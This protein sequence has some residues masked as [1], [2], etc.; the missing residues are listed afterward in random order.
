MI[1][2][3]LQYNCV[4]KYGASLPHTDPSS[5]LHLFCSFRFKICL[6]GGEHHKR[7]RTHDPVNPMNVNGL[8]EPFRTCGGGGSRPQ[9][10][11]STTAESCGTAAVSRNRNS[12]AGTP[13]FQSLA[14]GGSAYIRNNQ[15]LYSTSYYTE[16]SILPKKYL[17]LS[18]CSKGHFSDIFASSFHLPARRN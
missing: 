10:V 6:N 12:G 13:Q 16:A 14:G 7:T 9:S 11:R 3:H 2:V 5:V 8:P 18:D 1:F 15:V 4:E 17:Y